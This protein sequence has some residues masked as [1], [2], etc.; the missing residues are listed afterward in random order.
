MVGGHV[1]DNPGIRR[2]FTQHLAGWDSEGPAD[3][4]V[5][6]TMADRGQHEPPNHLGSLTP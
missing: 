4:D 6:S 5:I 2:L 3:L 1:P